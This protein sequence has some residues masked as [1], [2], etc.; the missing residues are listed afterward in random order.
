MLSFTISV[1]ALFVGY[2][3]YSRVAE[4]VF[5]PDDRETPAIRKADKSITSSCPPG[6]SS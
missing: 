4:R 6:A 3:L 2:M 5:G 1:I